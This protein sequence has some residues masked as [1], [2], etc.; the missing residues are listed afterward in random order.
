MTKKLNALFAT[1]NVVLGAILLYGIYSEAITANADAIQVDHVQNM[2]SDGR[3]LHVQLGRFDSSTGTM[4]SST[5][6][7]LEF[8]PRAASEL[9]TGISTMR[10]TA[11][12]QPSSPTGEPA[13][14]L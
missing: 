2:W 3:T 7:R 4:Q 12:N 1:V 9:G 6:A 11:P 14:T 8:T 13:S 10:N 5:V